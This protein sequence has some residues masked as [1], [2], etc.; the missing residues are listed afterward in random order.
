MRKAILKRKRTWSPKWSTMITIILFSIC[1]FSCVFLHA[2]NQKITPKL[3]EIATQEMNRM[4]YDIFNDYTFFTKLPNS[5]LK[6]LL[7]IQTNS[8]GEIVNVNYNTK[9]AYTI[10]DTIIKE[11]KENLAN[12]QQDKVESKFYLKSQFQPEEGVILN[13]PIGLASD[14]VYFANLGPKIPVKMKMMETVLT[15]L[16]TRIKDYGINN[17][18]VEVYVDVSINYELITPVTFD[19]KK[20]NYEILLAAEIINGKIP[21]YYGGLY[22]TKSNILNV[23]IN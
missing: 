4:I 1:F 10:A 16:K 11:V 22:E 14:N 3:I 19:Q 15:N 13:F 21:T 8:N 17:A 9:K 7:S 5:L 6:D 2:F 12:I 20:L 18:L 23:P